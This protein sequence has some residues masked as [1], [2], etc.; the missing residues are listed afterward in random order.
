[1]EILGRIRH[2]NVVKLYACLLKGG[3]S[4]L[5]Y[6]YMP[7]GNLFE[8]IHRRIKDW[9]HRYRIALGA[10][11]GISYLHHDCSPPVVHRDIKSSNVLL[12]EDYEAK[13]ADFGVAKLAEVT[14]DQ[15]GC[16]HSCFAGTHGYIAPGRDGL[17][18]K[19]DRKER[20]V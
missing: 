19:S 9:V 13:I 11:K 16:D 1:M 17:F 3:C 10:A 6:E 18:A 7:N 2:R 5:V 20:C 15:Q 4:Y 8:A 12:D 14:R